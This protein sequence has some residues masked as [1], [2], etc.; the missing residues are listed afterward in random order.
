[1]KSPIHY[2]E[3]IVSTQLENPIVNLHATQTP[4]KNLTFQYRFDTLDVCNSVLL[5][6]SLVCMDFMNAK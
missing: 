6:A 1:M 5:R 4:E 2:A 3:F